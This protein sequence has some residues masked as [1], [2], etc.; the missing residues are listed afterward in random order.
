[1]YRGSNIRRRSTVSHGGAAAVAAAAAAAA[2]AA[3]RCDARQPEI[4]RLK[5]SLS[6]GYSPHRI[7][8]RWREAMAGMRSLPVLRA[9]MSSSRYRLRGDS[10]LRMGGKCS[11]AL[12]QPLGGAQAVVVCYNSVVSSGGILVPIVPTT[13]IIFRQVAEVINHRFCVHF[14][15]PSFSLDIEFSPK[16]LNVLVLRS[17]V[18]T[19]QY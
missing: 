16:S 13:S 14:C 3:H 5:E 17:C 19:T 10:T 4:G 12:N 11:S 15:E 6:S 2:A 7:T 1:M 18:H 9:V 8:D